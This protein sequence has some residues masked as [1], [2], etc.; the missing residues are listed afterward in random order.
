MR[1]INDWW[2]FGSSLFSVTEPLL[3]LFEN[4]RLVA[5]ALEFSDTLLASTL[6]GPSFYVFRLVTAANAKWLAITVVCYPPSASLYKFPTAES[7]S[8]IVFTPAL[9]LS[10]FSIKPKLDPF[11]SIIFFRFF[12]LFYSYLCSLFCLS[13]S[14]SSRFLISRLSIS[15]SFSTPFFKRA[16]Y[17]ECASRKDSSDKF[18]TILL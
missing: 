2:R 11:P 13:R 14:L 8:V 12:S 16:K 4:C 6:K 9:L 10:S 18:C 17:S 15:L 5:A 3:C 1:P 7:V